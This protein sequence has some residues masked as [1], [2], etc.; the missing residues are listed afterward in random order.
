[1]RH[2]W[3]P[4]LCCCVVAIAVAPVAASGGADEGVTLANI[5]SDGPDTNG[6]N[7]VDIAINPLQPEEPD[8]GVERLRPGPNRV[9]FGYSLDGGRTW[10][11]SWLHGVTPDGGNALFD[12]GAG[13]PSVGFLNDGTAVLSCAAWGASK[14]QPSAVFASRSTDGGR[15]WAPAQQ[16]TFGQS[17]GHLQDHQHA[18]S[19]PLTATGRWSRT[20]CGTATTRAP[21]RSSPRTAAARTRGRTRSRPIYKANA[22]DLLRRLAG[23]RAGRDDLRHDRHLAARQRVER[24]GGA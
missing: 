22:V 24:A 19:R 17:L 3:L 18:H 1:M 5:S 2:L 23:R 20:A 21:T 12:Y 16:L 14:S 8:R 15:T 9:G 11:T 4:A 6:D 10:T 13:D 7:E